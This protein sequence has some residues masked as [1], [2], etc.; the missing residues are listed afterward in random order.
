MQR[1]F[2]SNGK[3]LLS[4]EYAILDGAL[5]LAVPTKFGQSLSIYPIEKPLIQW[6]SFEQDNTIWFEAE[7]SMDNFTINHTTDSEVAHTLQALLVE[8]KTQNRNFL[9]EGTGFRVESHL[10]FPRNWGLGSS[11]TL[12]NNIAQWAQVDAYHLLWNAFG[13]SSYD[14]AC[15]QHDYPITYALKDRRPIAKTAHFNPTFKDSLFFVYLNQKQSSKE[16]IE[17]YRKQSFDKTKLVQDISLLT[18]KMIA[19]NSLEVFQE[20]LEEHE[21][22]ISEVLGIKPVQKK[23][24]PDYPGTIKSLGAWGG[25]FIWV[26]GDEKTREY[27]ISKGFE[28]VIPYSEMVL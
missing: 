12:I 7:L 5:G 16:A 23:L 9:L 8:A 11:S 4:G 20:L 1:E 28:T 26:T 13:G 10:T 27:F 17:A 25:D 14:I 21:A 18:Q 6:T 22:L 24:F 2:Y 19:V 3:L 15:A